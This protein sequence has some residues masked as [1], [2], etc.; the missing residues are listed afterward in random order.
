M[1]SRSLILCPDIDRQYQ[2]KKFAQFYFPDKAKYNGY[3]IKIKTPQVFKFGFIST[4]FSL[5]DTL[6]GNSI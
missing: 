1:S 2:L 6:L 5:H 3:D 4:G